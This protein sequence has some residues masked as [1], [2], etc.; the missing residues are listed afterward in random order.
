MAYPLSRRATTG[1]MR[2]EETIVLRALNEFCFEPSMCGPQDFV[3]TQVLYAKYRDYAKGRPDC[4]PHLILN[5]QG[6]GAALR[7]VFD[8][9][10]ARKTRRSYQGKQLPGYLYVQGPGAIKARDAEG[11]PSRD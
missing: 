11:R 9:D 10:P 3:P 5:I 1:T 6:F 2:P 7:R 8:L 4:P